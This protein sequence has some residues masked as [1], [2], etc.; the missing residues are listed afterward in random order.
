[1]FRGDAGRVGWFTWRRFYVWERVCS[2]KRGLEGDGDGTGAT[3]MPEPTN[4]SEAA[5]FEVEDGVPEEG[6]R[7]W[8]SKVSINM[9][10]DSEKW[11]MVRNQDK[12]T[13]QI[14]VIDPVTPG[15]SS[16]V[17]SD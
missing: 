14:G 16:R 11:L 15:I 3:C 7:S 6:R 2:P 8:Q 5:E 4:M 9:R 12:K 1:M 13:I 17:S 10:R